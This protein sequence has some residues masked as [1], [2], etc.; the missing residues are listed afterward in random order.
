MVC[1]TLGIR[2]QKTVISERWEAN[3]VSPVIVPT[4]RDYPLF[5]LCSFERFPTQAEPSKP[6]ELKKS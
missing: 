6:S 2:Q 4:L 5:N 1:G 3:G